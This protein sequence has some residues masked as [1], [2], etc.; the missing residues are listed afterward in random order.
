MHKTPQLIVSYS[1]GVESTN[2]GITTCYET[3]R[4]RMI[5]EQHA[6]KQPLKALLQAARMSGRADQRDRR[7]P[8]GARAG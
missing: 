3:I 2:R 5:V 8:L 7:S 1:D 6:S 4:V